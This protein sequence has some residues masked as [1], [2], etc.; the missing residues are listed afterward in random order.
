MNV[1]LDTSVVLRLLVGVPTGQSETARLFIAESDAPVGISDLVI[2]ETYFALRH[3]YAVPHADAVHALRALLDDSRIRGTG[4]ARTVLRD[5]ASSDA[6]RPRPGLID[7]LVHGDYTRD[8]R[9]L[10]T[11]DRDLA[12]LPNVRLLP[13]DA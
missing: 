3:H 5:L 4:V 9:Q 8:E 12:R 11:F 13:S 2:S 6:A 10:A 1:G 7:R